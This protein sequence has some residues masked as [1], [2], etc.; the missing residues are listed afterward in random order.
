[1]KRLL[2]VIILFALAYCQEC[3]AADIDK[4]LFGWTARNGS[5]MQGVLANEGVSKKNPLGKQNLASDPGNFHNGKNCG[6]TVA[7]I[8]CRDNPKFP[9][10]TATIQD[11][12]DYYHRNQWAAIHGDEII[13]QYL[14][15][16]IFRLAINMGT[17]TAIILV[18]KT[19]NDLNGE[20]KDYPL[21]GV[22]TSDMV[23]WL[24][25]FTAPQTLVD[26]TESN[27]R[28]WCFF[29]QLKLNALDRY[30]DL[31]AGNPKLRVFWEN[32]SGQTEYD[33]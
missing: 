5:H 10:K 16:K 22:L 3:Y 12:T 30:G 7:G 32:W 27:W 15:F 28:R 6:G 2:L 21:H 26:G 13:S 23:Q 1:M 11:V 8:C 31:I 18:E 29:A 9:F 25:E 4:A 20:A 14:A 24:N 19:I 33:K 17:G